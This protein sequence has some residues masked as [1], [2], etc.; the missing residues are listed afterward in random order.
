MS[1]QSS[2]MFKKDRDEKWLP[3]GE[4]MVKFRDAQRELNERK[5]NRIAEDFDPYAI[6]RVQVARVNGSYHIVDGQHRVA[7]VQ[8]LWGDDEMVPCDVIPAESAAEAAELFLKVN[9]ERSPVQAIDRFK[10]AVQAGRED[11]VEVNDLL[12]GLGYK[13]SGGQEDGYFAAVS[14]AMSVHRKYGVGVLKDALLLIQ[15]TWGMNRDS[16]HT[17]L[18]QGFAGLVG[19][20]G[21]AIDRKRLVG[22]VSKEYTP[23]RLIGAAKTAREMF[24][25][26][27]PAN[28]E[29]VLV[30]TYNHGLRT[31]M[32]LEEPGY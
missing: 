2:G 27:V 28:V 10:I 23:A 4:L 6:G 26:T 5:V 12:T 22:R 9:D 3:V 19:E 20:Q 31:E 17:A 11:Y 18:V 8:K 30:S 13:V 21:S 16:V 24:R 32:R 29:R 1:K 14:A 7:A 15:A 25:G